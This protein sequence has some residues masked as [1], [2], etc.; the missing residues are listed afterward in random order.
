MVNCTEAGLTLGLFARQALR[1]STAPP[2][3]HCR[4]PGLDQLLHRL[5]RRMGISILA[6]NG[7]TAGIHQGLFP[8]YLLDL[9]PEPGSTALG[10]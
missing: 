9:E 7:S 2:F 8:Q 5:V 4:Q 6:D 3:Y 1:L 10:L